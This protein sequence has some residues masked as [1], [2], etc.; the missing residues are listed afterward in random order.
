MWKKSDQ[1]SKRLLLNRVKE[2]YFAAIFIP[3][4][5]DFYDPNSIYL[6]RNGRII[7]NY[8][9]VYKPFTCR[10]AIKFAKIKN[11]RLTT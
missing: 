3:Q 11:L 10:E 2:Y 4:E 5:S 6:E 7:H 8:S 9:W 1:R